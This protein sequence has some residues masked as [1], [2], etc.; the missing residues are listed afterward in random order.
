MNEL[1]RRYRRML[2]WYP[3]EHRRRYEDEMVETLVAGARPDQRRPSLGDTA[4][5]ARNA[6]ASHVATAVRGFSDPRWAN[7]FAVTGLI[8]AIVMLGTRVRSIAQ[9]V[10]LDQIT[11]NYDS[12]GRAAIVRLAIWLAVVALALAGPRVLAAIAAWFAVMAEIALSVYMV[13]PLSALNWL[14]TVLLGT[15]CATALTVPAAHRAGVRLL[16]RHRLILIGLGCAAG[17]LGSAAGAILDIQNGRSSGMV[18]FLPVRLHAASLLGAAVAVAFVVTAVV[19][20]DGGVRR[21]VVALFAPL[22]AVFG[23]GQFASRYIAY[24]SFDIRIDVV[25]WIGLGLTVAVTFVGAVL[26][27]QR[28]EQRLHLLELGRAADRS[29]V[30]TDAL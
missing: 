12:L 11:S 28:R 27:V 4:N 22:L 14:W 24:A 30:S 17:I 21:R 9:Y 29:T 23:L 18:A 1:E 8:A 10:A 16:G 20:L 19:T 13:M 5:L 2:A 7:A 26:L 25:R 15:T 3:W 6:L